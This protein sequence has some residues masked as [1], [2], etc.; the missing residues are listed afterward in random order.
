MAIYQENIARLDLSIGSFHRSFLNKMIGEGDTLADRFG[1]EVMRDG[2]PVSLGN[3]TCTG[4][5]IRPDGTTVVISGTVNNNIAY[6]SLPALCYTVEGQ[7]TLAIKVTGGGINGTLRIVDGTVVNTT[8]DEV[9][10]TGGSVP[11]VAAMITLAERIEAAAETIEG[12]SVTTELNSGTDYTLV[13]VSET[14]DS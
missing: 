2:E 12:F 7:F 6:V 1:V 10:A 9:T 8:T 4:Y 14:E 13:V 11:S 5:F 3:S